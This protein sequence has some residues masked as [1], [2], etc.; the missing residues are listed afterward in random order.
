MRGRGGPRDRKSELRT[1][2][3]KRRRSIGKA[4]LAE[5]SSRVEANLVAL[6]EYRRARLLIS[7]CA[8]DDE[9]QTRPIIERALAEG[10]RV[11]VVST[12][13]RT[14]RLGFSEIASFEDDLAPGAFG[15]LEP[16]RDRL[17]P[18]SIAEADLVLVPLV[19][20]DERGHRL[21]Y[22][23][24]YFD[25]ALAGTDVLKVGLALES[26]RLPDVPESR[27]DVPLDVIVTDRRVVRPPRG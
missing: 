5:L 22:G 24:G 1:A 23:A 8:K 15:I 11:A 2:A 21:G 16:R 27:H 25:R 3:L 12:D 4:E 14:L 18:V 26:Q 7:Y 10:K 17:R 13:V 19:A 6:D 20:W 9:V